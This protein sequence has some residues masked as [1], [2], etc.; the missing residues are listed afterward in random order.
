M[1]VARLHVTHCMRTACTACTLHA[2]CMCSACAWRLHVEPLLRC[3]VRGELQR[4]RRD[5]GRDR[6]GT[7]RRGGERAQ[8]GAAA[9][10]ERRQAL[11]RWSRG[12]QLGE[13]HR[14]RPEETAVVEARFRRTGG[15]T[16]RLQE[17]LDAGR[18]VGVDVPSR[19][20]H[21]HARIGQSHVARTARQFNYVQQKNAT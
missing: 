6:G 2:L 8:A 5:V 20:R 9:E 13:K 21:G 10:L 4:E 19:Q 18:G 14:S 17:L 15:Q 12:Q 3:R 11:Q 16:R 7:T 1:E